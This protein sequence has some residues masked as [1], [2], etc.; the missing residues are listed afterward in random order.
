M[1]DAVLQQIAIGSITP[2]PHNPRR[3]RK[4][5]AELASLADSIRAKGVLQPILVRPMPDPLGT[6]KVPQFELIA[7][8]RRWRAS[9]IAER[10]AIPAIV[11]EGL[12]DQE[13]LELTVLENLQREDLS[14]LEEAA[15]VAS[16]LA[17]GKPLSEVADQLGKPL[18]WVARRSRIASL[19]PTW[20][21]LAADPESEVSGW[22]VGHLELVAR[23]EPAAQDQF[24][25][26]HREL[27]EKNDWDPMTTREG[28]EG[29]LAEFTHELSLAPWNAADATLL[30]VVGACTTCPKRSSVNPG[31]FDDEELTKGKRVAARDRCLDAVCWE[32]KSDQH[33][34]Q[35]GGELIEKHRDLVIEK[36]EGEKPLPAFARGRDV[37][38]IW[39]GTLAK[40]GDPGAVPVLITHGID[41]GTLEWR[42][43]GKDGGATKVKA[44]AE[45]QVKSMAE[46]R[47][48]L[49]GRRQ[50]LAMEATLAALKK[51]KTPPTGVLLRFLRA[52][53]TNDNHSHPLHGGGSLG[54]PKSSLGQSQGPAEDF[55]WSSVVKVIALRWDRT[56]NWN[57]TGGVVRLLPEI[58]AVCAMAGVDQAPFYAAAVKELPEPKS[59]AK[60]TATKR[61]KAAPAKKK[62]SK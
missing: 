9:K 37:V 17:G 47:A 13:A 45:P 50:A 2:S 28:L 16:L 61:K 27:K 35:V 8:E 24:L 21:K 33:F 34:E 11:R 53:G 30:P 43:F 20:Q 55:L 54:A 19:S 4:D 31:L 15:G 60:E 5:D 44:G 42:K 57:G 38:E 32:R 48:Q 3:F 6:D 23:L 56:R 39:K 14:P 51:S 41:R 62:A 12:T 49:E 36:P 18:S 25:D 29:E 10:D 59:W 26:E 7:G 22:P 46:R 40:K 58:E 52:Y 1:S